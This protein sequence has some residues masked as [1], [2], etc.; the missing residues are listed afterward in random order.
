M[1]LCLGSL[2]WSTGLSDYTYSSNLYI[3]S[4]SIS[5]FSYIPGFCI[6]PNEF[7]VDLLHSIESPAGMLI[8]IALNS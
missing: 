8:G 5:K 7:K 3:S 1:C 2:F 4:Y 6:F